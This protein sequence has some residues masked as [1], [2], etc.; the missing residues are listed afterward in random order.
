[1]TTPNYSTIANSHTLQFTTAHIKSSQ[2]AVPSLVI[3]CLV[4]DNNV[5]CFCAHILTGWWL[6]LRVKLLYDWQFT[7]NQFVL[8]PSPLSPQPVFFFQ[9]NTCS[10]SP[11][12]ISSLTRRRVCHLQW[13]LVLASTVILESESCGTHVH[14]LLSQIWDS[15]KTWTARCLYLY[16]PGIGWPS[17]SPRHW[18]PFSSSPLTH[19]A[20]VEVFDPTST[21]G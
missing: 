17:Y 18:V 11:Y 10:Y 7:V 12:V 4:M 8:V 9:L 13:L 20:T 5:L 14:I 15:L 1:V 21:Q 6:L 19:W 2:C 3:D 16:P